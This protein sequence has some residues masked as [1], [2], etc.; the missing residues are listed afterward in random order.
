MII[1]RLQ[2][3]LPDSV[4]YSV[5]TLPCLLHPVNTFFSF[6]WNT[7]SCVY[8]TKILRVRP[9]LNSC[10][11]A[12]DMWKH[13]FGKS[14]FSAFILLNTLTREA[15]RWIWTT[16]SARMC[17]MTDLTHQTSVKFE[18][19]F[20]IYLF[21][22]FF[23]FSPDLDSSWNAQFPP[24]FICLAKRRIEYLLQLESGK[25]FI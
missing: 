4:T 3:Y 14:L 17:I 22:D 1:N 15:H 23:L 7:L 16:S 8:D 10:G 5:V 6:F 2:E 18:I 25:W 9:V 21:S 13:W 11:P 19:W 20:Q 24:P 12:A